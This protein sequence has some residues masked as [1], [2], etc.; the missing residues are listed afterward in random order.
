MIS[1]ENLTK[2]YGSK[3]ALDSI[4]FTAEDCEV[5]GLLGPN[6]AGKTTTMRILTGYF[7]PT[8]GTAVIAG[9]D[10]VSNPAA[11]REKIGYLPETVPL[12][13]D[14]TVCEFLDFAASIK[15]VDRKNLDSAV[16][17]VVELCGL[18][19][20]VNAPI[21]TIS[22][23]YRQR[24]GI[25]QAVINKPELIVLDEP[26]VGLDPS[27]VASLRTLILQLSKHS[28]IM[29]SSHI[30]E[31]ISKICHKVL[32]IKQGKLL[33]ADTPENLSTKLQEADN[34]SLELSGERETVEKLLKERQGIRKFELSRSPDDSSILLCRIVA[35]RDI[36]LRAELVKELVSSG[37]AL[38]SLNSE[39]MSLEEVFTHIVEGE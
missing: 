23:G 15:G 36:K 24:V 16:D 7:P 5:V 29:I 28:T 31:E 21:S 20:Y 34:L 6:G 17:E 25:A 22:K 14:M 10:V 11:V 30:L 35:D 39:K 9:I 26:T 32:I 27:Q 2:Y 4:S 38:Y 33:A 8:S 1:V 3:C 12:Y 13:K 19:D 18:T 37:I